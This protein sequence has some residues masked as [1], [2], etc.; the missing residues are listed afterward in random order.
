[1]TFRDLLRRVRDSS[2]DA[3]AYQEVPFEKIVDVLHP[4]RNLSHSPLFQVMFALQSAVGQQMPATG[5]LA[6]EPVMAHSGTAKFDLTLF[7]LEDG[8]HLSGALEFNTDLFDALTMHRMLDHFRSLLTAAV[9]RPQAQVGLL[10]LLSGEETRTI[11]SEWNGAALAYD[12]VRPF[13]VRF[14]DSVKDHPDAPACI[15]SDGR[16]TYRELNEEANRLARYLQSCRVG[17][18][19]L[20]GLFLERSPE[21][22][23][24]LLATLKAG[25]AYVPLDPALPP[26]RIAYMIADAGMPVILSTT[27]TAGRLPSTTSTVIHIDSVRDALAAFSAGNLTDAVDSEHLAYV[28][29]TSGSTG[30]PKGTLITHKGL[31]NY[32][33]WCL[34]AY[35]Y[36]EGRG[37][38]VHSTLAFDATVTALLPSLLAGT[39][40]TLLPEAEALD[41]LAGHLRATPGYSVLKITPAHL[42]VLGQQLSASE[43]EEMARAL[44]VGGENLTRHHLAFLPQRIRPTV[45]NEYGP[46]ETVVGCIVYEVTEAEFAGS[47]VPIGKPIPNTT[48]YVLDEDLHPVP[49]GVAGELYLGGVGLARGYLHRADLTAERFLPDPFSATLG[50]RLYR[51]GDVAKF[52]Q[53]G[54]ME[55]L[56]RADD[57]VKLHGY[58]I[59]PGEIEAVLKHHPSLRDAVVLVREDQ[60]GDKRLVGY[61]VS[62]ADV[63]P[64]VQELRGFLGSQLP[65]Y[66]VP[67]TWVVLESIP[68][69]HNGKVDRKALPHPEMTREILG[70]TY[71]APETPQER[72]L[73]GI[74]QDVLG[75][76]QVGVTDNF[77]ELGGDSILSIQIIARANQFGLR[78]TPMQLFQHPTVEALAAVAGTGGLAEN[79]QG[80]VTGNVP[81]TPIQRWFFEHTVP[82]RDHWNQSLLF[83]AGTPLD[84]GI[85]KQLVR[86]L[87]EHHDILRAR[88][89][90]AA[91]G[92]TQVLQA[93]PDDDLLTVVS[94]QSGDPDIGAEVEREAERWQRSLDL[95]N[96]PVFRV[97]VMDCGPGRPSRLLLVAHH[98]VIDA[99]S[100]QI[101]LDDLI[102][103][104]RQ[105]TEGKPVQLP[106]KTTSFRRWAEGLIG[107]ARSPEGKEEADYWLR[108]QNLPRAPM[109]RDFA[110]G[111][112]TESSTKTFTISISK[113]DTE[114]LLR[115]GLRAYGVE[116]NDILLTALAQTLTAWTGETSAYLHLEGHGREELVPGLDITRTVGWFTALFPVLLSLDGENHHPSVVQRV[117][118]QLKGI[119]RRGAG[120]GPVRYLA[121]PETTA[122][123]SLLP[124][125]EISF[126]YLGQMDRPGGGEALIRSA[127]EAKGAERDPAAIR[128]HLLEV[129]G[130]I[131]GGCLQ[132]EWSYS[133]NIHMRETIES[134][135]EAFAESLRT[136]I[137]TAPE[138]GT[139]ETSAFEVSDFGW[140]KGDVE[141]ILSG[142]EDQGGIE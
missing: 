10:P 142:L 131:Q 26:E 62:A 15:W 115:R 102:L 29:Y 21:M 124:V 73:A 43:I 105:L 28:I 98:L 75:L 94:L 35:P 134:L 109:P 52:L 59:E 11:L 103:G 41:N 45:Y 95:R 23:L 18:D 88:F 44:V 136:L 3:F 79:E 22:I 99:V 32:L 61:V 13:H 77:F 65:P 85:L 104:Y 17:P 69:T 27:A 12:D 84:S 9:A 56:S 139:V 60:P 2:L 80:S 19:T 96:G 57:Q 31:S 68:L 46:T 70:S 140:S 141:Q 118:A 127:R 83:E 113:E 30:R 16:W 135:A 67:S 90:E 48:A 39:S 58:R 107:F 129:D 5:E 55:Y 20:V 50:R 93:E 64:T 53:D 1:M 100:W 121:D 47:S 112:N 71:V 97:V 72:I 106:L 49:P 66:M 74:W 42:K 33:N 54:T 81:L 82:A 116:I 117:R 122:G 119:P 76:P 40:V 14:E 6:I 101:I 128:S 7:M 125:P 37:T 138:D 36:R 123:M 110:G 114:V 126:N 108:L 86:A 34:R 130:G 87:V 137:R 133:E 89:V 91:D 78:L 25:G 38:L 111:I 63:A 120:Y 4:E 92:W 8:D 132:F 24:G 51:T